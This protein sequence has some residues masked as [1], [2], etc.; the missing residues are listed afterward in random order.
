MNAEP[1]AIERLA[2]NALETTFDRFDAK[3]VAA[4]IRRIIDTLGCTIG[5]SGDTGNPELVALVKDQGGKP[6]ATIIIDGAKVP[7][8]SAA[9]VNGIMTRSFDFEPVSPLVDGVNTPGHISGTTVP[10]ALAVAEATG[11]SGREMMTALLVGDDIAA[12]VLAASG[13]G[14]TLGW[15]GVGTVNVFGATAIAG[16]LLGLTKRQLRHAFGLCLQLLGTTFQTIWDGTTAFKLPQG[17]AG[18]QGILAAQLAKADWTG[19][20]DALFSKFGYY[21]M[22]TEGCQKPE[23][24]T[25]R[26]G[27]VYYYD[28]IT[29]PYPACRITH[30]PIDAS[31]AIIR[32]HGLKADDVKNVNLDLAQAGIDH[33]CGHPFAPGDNPHT[34]AAFSYQYTV[35]TA[36]VHGEVTP[37]QFAPAA[38][39]D[40]K[41][42][43]FFRKITLTPADDVP[44]EGARVTVT[45]N[46][47]RRFTETVE[48]ANG[49]PIYN[50]IGPDA[51][52]AKFWSNVDYNGKL[53]RDKATKLLSLLEKLDKLDDV[54]KLMPFLTA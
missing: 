40:P 50:P 12:R 29:K 51:V 41:V 18:Q 6:E 48:V 11:S 2:A 16:R 37:R 46:D 26:L 9:F 42:H 31:L 27:E 1:T 4:T 15:D 39:A 28:G 36:F 17:L 10:T 30:A 24:L 44:F 20:E 7:A 52:L 43:D 33:K 32:Q 47:G 19:P 38:L 45:T 3:T 21:N 25:D 22:F 8:G 35:A 54:R 14:F 53:G 13:F 34:N 23:Y 5:G 49:N